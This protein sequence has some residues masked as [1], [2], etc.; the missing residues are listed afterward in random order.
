MH[1]SVTVQ[2]LGLNYHSGVILSSFTSMANNPIIYMAYLG[3]DQSCLVASNK[4]PM[5]VLPLHVTFT[6]STPIQ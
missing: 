1:I 3:G 6:I 2:Y 4:A 5:Y